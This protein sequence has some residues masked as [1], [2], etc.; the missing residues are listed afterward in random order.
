M[1]TMTAQESATLTAAYDVH[2]RNERTNNKWYRW[3]NA[4]TQ[5]LDKCHRWIE[6]YNKPATVCGMVHFAME[7][8]LRTEFRIIEMQRTIIGTVTRQD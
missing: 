5:N 6:E 1:Q 8:G 2:Y 3:F 7:K 4:P